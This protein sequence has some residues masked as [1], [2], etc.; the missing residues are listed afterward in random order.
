MLP[1]YCTIAAALLSVLVLMSPHVGAAESSSVELWGG[2]ELGAGSVRRSVTASDHSDTTFYMAVKGGYAVS[3]R[4]L[5]G[6]QLGG[7]TFELDDLWDPEKGEGISQVFLIAQYYLRSMREG[8]YVKGGAGYVSYWNNSPGGLEDDGWGAQFGLGYDWQTE[9]FGT[10]G[11]LVMF[12]YAKAGD[13][14]HTGV[15]LALNWSFP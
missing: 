6:A 10:L 1:H 13:F 5:L 12:D 7:Y 3:E 15:A 11:P 14:D 2:V 9:G 4:L 8:W